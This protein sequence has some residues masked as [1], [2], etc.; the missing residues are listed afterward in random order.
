MGNSKLLLNAP[1]SIDNLI[2]HLCN[3]YKNNTNDLNITLRK[4]L[5]VFLKLEFTKII[6]YSITHHFLW[7]LCSQKQTSANGN[8][9]TCSKYKLCQYCTTLK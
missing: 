6:P 2:V 9:P 8:Q 5:K 4:K 7:L 3:N 1:L